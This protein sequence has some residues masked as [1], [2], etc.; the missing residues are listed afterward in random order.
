M[1]GSRTQLQRV[2][3]PSSCVTKRKKN[4]K[5]FS[6]LR[7]AEPSFCCRKYRACKRSSS[8][9][10]SR[11]DRTTHRSKL[12]YIES[13]A[14]WIHSRISISYTCLFALICHMRLWRL[15]IRLHC[16]AMHRLL[17]EEMHVASLIF[18]RVI[19]Y[20]EILLPGSPMDSLV[21]FL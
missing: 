3:R 14:R 2:I 15:I 10:F 8:A 4:L 6:L 9:P 17:S 19:L 7:M 20:A 18:K 21:I 5:R 16:T 1:L 13:N 11:N 12:V